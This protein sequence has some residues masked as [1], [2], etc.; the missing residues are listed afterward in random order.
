MH[1]QSFSDLAPIR[2]PRSGRAPAR[3]AGRSAA[4]ER[5]LG[6]S[7]LLVAVTLAVVLW[8]GIPASTGPTTTVTV[9]APVA[10]QIY[11][12]SKGIRRL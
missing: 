10:S 8:N 3:V 6:L 2:L 12:T 4:V 11:D 7:A 9:K 5:Q 1:S